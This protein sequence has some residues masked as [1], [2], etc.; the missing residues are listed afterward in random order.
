MGRLSL[1][2][3]LV[4]KDLRHRPTSA[5]LMLLAITTATTV[6]TLGLAL[7]GVT[8]HPYQQTQTA[9]HGP[10]V[11]AQLGGQGTGPQF[12]GPPPSGQ[13][14]V[15]PGQGAG[16]PGQGAGPPG[17][18]AGSA[19]T[20]TGPSAQGGGPHG[21]GGISKAQVASE[22]KSLVHAAGVTGHSGPFPVASARLTVHGHTVGIEVEGRDQ[23]PTA[24]EQPEVT[25]GTWVRPGGIVLERTFAQALGVRVGDRVRLNGRPLTVTGIAVTAAAPPYPNLCYSPGG[26]TCGVFD[27]TNPPASARDI[28]FGWATEPTARALAAAVKAPLWYFLDLKLKH[29]ASA[30]GFVSAHAS[31]SAGGQVLVPWQDIASADG[32]LVQDEQS[33]LSPG[34]W[35]ACLLAMASVAVLAGGRMADQTRRIGLLKAVGATPGLVTRV[36]LTENLV[37]A[38]TSAAAGLLLGWLTAPLLTNPGAGLVGS[39][40]APALTPAIVGLVAGAAV[41]VTLLATIASAIRAASTSTVSALANAARTPRRRATLIAISARLPVALLLGLRLVARRPR[42]ALLSAASIAVTMTGIVTVL[43]FHAT[44]DQARYG[45]AT[46]LGDPVVQRDEQML[47]VLTVVLVALAAL[48]A[49]CATWTTV[50]D[51]RRASALARALGA[52]PSQVTLGLAAAQVIPALPGALLGVPLGI[53]L[54]AAVNGAN[55]RTIPAAPWLVLAVLGTLVGT[56]LLTSVPAR[57]GARHPVAT[58][59][60]GEAV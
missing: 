60:Q 59:L 35:L 5:V 20:G 53:E 9:T 58:I 55:I 42:R 13:G 29:L 30:L 15:P 40:G 51:A 44:A 36:L 22:V 7:H 18:G 12:S 14:A 32:L 33:V 21:P 19:G 54:F 57:I 34:S 2:A 11:V 43:A 52:T 49:L 45:T 1:I 8:G 3:R 41:L 27:L 28:G 16:P 17:Q 6:L 31:L 24:I 10:D 48:N 56:A 46:G 38:L 50:L 4:S 25:T 26:G 37:I 39:P 47:A 23:Q